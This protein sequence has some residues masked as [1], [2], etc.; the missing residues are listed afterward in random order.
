MG[1]GS[2][3]ERRAMS[4]R[5]KKTDGGGSVCAR[6]WGQEGKSWRGQ[7]R[8]RWEVGGNGCIE[9]NGPVM[10][11]GGGESWRKRMKKWRARDEAG[12]F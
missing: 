5:L 1:K 3:A 4:G 12:G 11:G 6:A 8:E 10:L 9:G 7:Q 2:L